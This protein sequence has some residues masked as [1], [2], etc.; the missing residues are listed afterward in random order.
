M[1]L[2]THKRRWKWLLFI[3]AV[4]ALAAILYYSS[5]LLKDIAREERSKVALWAEA[6]KHKAQL[7]NSTTEFFN[8]IK[9]DE[10]RRV[11]KFGDILKKLNEVSTSEELTFY[12]NELEENKKNNK[13]PMIL[14]SKNGDIS[15]SVNTTPEIQQ[16]RN[17]SEL[18]ALRSEYDSLV[19]HYDPTDTSSYV[20]I[21]YQQSKAYTDLHKS[22]E[23]LQESFF[24]DVVINTAS[25][26]VIITNKENDSIILFGNIDSLE[27]ATPESRMNLISS[28]S[29]EN[30]PLEVMLPDHGLCHVYYQESSVL[31]RLRYFP[32]I[33]LFII[34]VFVLVAY[35]LF[36]VARRSEQNRVWVGMSKETAH[37]LGTPISSLMAWT[38][39]LRESDVD[40]SLVSEMDKDVKRLDT[41]AQRFS[42]IGSVPEL[43]EENLVE[44]VRD[45]TNY[46]R[47]RLSS[48]VT[49]TFPA[50]QYAPV[51]L[52]I[53]RYLFEWVV[54]NICKNA[55]DAMN[56]EG[57]I[58]LQ[59]VEDSKCVHLDITDTGKGIPPQRQKTIFKPGYTS[60]KRG[61]GLGL[62]LAQRIIKDYHKGKLFVKSSTV[63]KGTTMRISLSKRRMKSAVSR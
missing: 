16:M 60:K 34:L 33:Q 7:V 11:Q 42:K 45:F 23:N 8:E 44:V 1:N 2:Y 56:G 25:I 51:I 40:P 35:I 53:N 54:E 63:G 62:T 58:T 57:S 49:I 4:I 24:Q 46:L 17:V 37:Q 14:A 20:T 26:P 3:T 9:Q 41:I 12:L 15:E 22:L 52:P 5:L 50:E 10:Q 18:G 28:M 38:E 21:Y 39:L 55:V 29:S 32:Y 47:T 43:H 27:V 31:K 36:S 61:W 59:L 48:R 6:V 30:T 13:F 19:L